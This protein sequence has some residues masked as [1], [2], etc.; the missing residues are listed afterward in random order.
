[1]HRGGD[2]TV[3]HASAQLRPPAAW[4][5]CQMRRAQCRAPYHT[6]GESNRTAVRDLRP[7]DPVAIP[8]EHDPGD[9]GTGATHLNVI[10]RDDDACEPR[11]G[12][13]A[14]RAIDEEYALPYRAGAQDGVSAD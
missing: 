3:P 14:E 1:M 5:P 4:R 6:A 12:F 10:L 7:A 11:T 13:H 9:R 2:G 8:R